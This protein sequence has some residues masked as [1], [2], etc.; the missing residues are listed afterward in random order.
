MQ[1]LSY[2]ERQEVA[3]AIQHELVFSELVTF[4][5]DDMLPFLLR[6][7]LF[8]ILCNADSLTKTDFIY[9]VILEATMA[10][11]EPFGCVHVSGSKTPHSKALDTKQW[12]HL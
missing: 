3:P 2:G 10:S 1:N 11:G 9:Y 7:F 5:Q 4:Y 8:Y 12:P 6:Y